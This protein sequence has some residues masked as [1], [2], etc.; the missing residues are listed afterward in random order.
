MVR[1]GGT[2]NRQLPGWEWFEITPV[3]DHR[4]HIVWRGVGPPKGEEYGGDPNGSC[5]T[6]HAVCPA[7]TCSAVLRLENFE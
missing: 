7:G 6:C 2:Y 5:N 1:R 4:S 3:D